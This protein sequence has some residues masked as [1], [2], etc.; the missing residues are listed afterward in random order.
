MLLLWENC[1]KN[2]EFRQKTWF[3][4]TCV[5]K[6]VSYGNVKR[7]GKPP[8]TNKQLLKVSVSQRKSPFQNCEKTSRLERVWRHAPPLYAVELSVFVYY[9]NTKTCLMVFHLFDDQMYCTALWEKKK[10]KR[11]EHRNTLP[12]ISWNRRPFILVSA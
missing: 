7:R 11:S 12:L 1:K 10:K 3:D 6:C 8:E 2:E 9:P 5:S 4:L